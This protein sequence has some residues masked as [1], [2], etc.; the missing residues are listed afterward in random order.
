MYDYNFGERSPFVT[1]SLRAACILR[2]INKHITR[3]NCLFILFNFYIIVVQQF[4]VFIGMCDMMMRPKEWQCRFFYVM[5]IFVKG[6]ADT[7]DKK[8]EEDLIQ[9]IRRFFR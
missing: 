1:A 8:G 6:I 3:F 9:I 4:S 2:Y 5:V 7:K